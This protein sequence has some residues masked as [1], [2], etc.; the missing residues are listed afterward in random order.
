[1]HARAQMHASFGSCLCA[2]VTQR[3]TCQTRESQEGVPL[4]TYQENALV[5]HHVLFLS[6]ACLVVAMCRPQLA[7]GL[8]QLFSIEQQKSQPLEAH[9]AAF[10]TV[11][12]R[13][14]QSAGQ[15]CW[16]GQAQL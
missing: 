1:M 12:V 3:Q 9:A 13:Q 2:V 7:R 10:S 4:V 6:A 5:A 14:L 8:M 11:K 16:W 15:M